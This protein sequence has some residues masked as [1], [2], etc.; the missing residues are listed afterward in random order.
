MQA[1]LTHHL[2]YDKHSPAGNNSG[3]SR[4]G[5][6]KKT[7]KGEFGNLPLEVP[8]DRNSTFEPQI[9][10]KGQTRFEGFDDKILSLYARGMTTRQIK[11]H[12]EEIYQVEVSPSLISSV[13]DAI[14]DEVKAWQSR[15]LD[16]SEERRVGKECGARVE[17]E[18][19][20]KRHEV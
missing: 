8:R 3:N 17:T 13:T 5:K 6:S 12:L 9:V 11:Q 2:G 15:P 16:R 19:V 7:L 4:N 14:S 1:E 20:Y 10:P 18:T